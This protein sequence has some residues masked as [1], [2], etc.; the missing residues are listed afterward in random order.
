VTTYSVINRQTAIGGGQVYCYNNGQFYVVPNL[1][2]SVTLSDAANAVSIYWSIPLQLE[3][4]SSSGCGMIA[5]LMRNGAA[6][7]LQQPFYLPMNT[8]GAIGMNQVSA[9]VDDLPGY[10]GPLVYQ[11]G[12]MTIVGGGR[13]PANFG[14]SG[15]ITCDEVQRT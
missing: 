1:Q 12:V 5:T 10:V 11:I 3:N 8:P 4:P 7:G 9:L 13:A 6:I 2:V 15:M 14:G